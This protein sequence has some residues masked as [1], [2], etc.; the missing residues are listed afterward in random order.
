MPPEKAHP[1]E[2]V[3][4]KPSPDEAPLVMYRALFPAGIAVEPTAP[5]G[6]AKTTAQSLAETLTSLLKEPEHS[7]HEVL[8]QVDLDWVLLGLNCSAEEESRCTRAWTDIVK[9]AA[10]P[11]DVVERVLSSPSD[12][13]EPQRSALD[14]LEA[15]LFDGHRYGR[16]PSLR[17]VQCGHDD[18]AHYYAATYRSQ[19]TRWGVRGDFPPA[20]LDQMSRAL[21]EQKRS[22]PPTMN[23]FSP[24]TWQQTR[25]A[26]LPT[27]APERS[28]LVGNTSSLSWGE[29]PTGAA[30]DSLPRRWA[31]VHQTSVIPDQTRVIDVLKR[32]LE[33]TKNG[34]PQEPSQMH[35]PLLG[36]LVESLPSRFPTSI[37]GPRSTEA[38]AWTYVLSSSTP[39]QDLEALQAAM[40]EGIISPVEAWVLESSPRAPKGAPESPSPNQEMEPAS[41]SSPS[42]TKPG[43][44]M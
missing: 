16:D 12:F 33:T 38:S 20:S 3:V 10:P 11:K 14:W 34:K 18:V 9:L 44:S 8:V 19:W 37:L 13:A 26:I 24:P 35:D 41:T 28:L 39:Q 36:A 17:C 29:F 40:A 4:V 2:L 21:S 30:P 42:T 7:T 31:M 22:V 6:L 1:S 43:A 15:L 32:D 27:R 25:V 5:R 23:R